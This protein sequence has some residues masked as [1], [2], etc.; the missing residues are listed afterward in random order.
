MDKQLQGRV[1]MTFCLIVFLIVNRLSRGKHKRIWVA[2]LPLVL[3]QR[4]GINQI[5]LIAFASQ[6]DGFQAKNERHIWLPT[7]SLKM[8]LL[9]KKKTAGEQRDSEESMT[10]T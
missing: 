10:K 2:V 1:C 5:D 7:Y 9:L 8:L 6:G 4:V 3:G